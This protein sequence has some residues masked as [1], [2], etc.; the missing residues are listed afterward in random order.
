ML[1]PSVRSDKACR[2]SISDLAL[3]RKKRGKT[4]VCFALCPPGFHAVQAN[5]GITLL[6]ERCFTNNALVISENYP[7]CS[8]Y[9]KTWLCYRYPEFL[10]AGYICSI[11]QFNFMLRQIKRTTIST[12]STCACYEKEV[13]RCTEQRALRPF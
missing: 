12:F 4:L 5:P 6:E 1:K 3:A 9:S 10:C 7:T 13:H 11:G 2:L 8:S